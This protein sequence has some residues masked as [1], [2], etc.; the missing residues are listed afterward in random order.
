MK[1]SDII[2]KFEEMKEQRGDLTVRFTVEDDYSVYGE[3]MTPAWRADDRFW[4]GCFT[5]GSKK[6]PGVVSI[7]FHLDDKID[8]ST[9]I[10]K[11][12]KI[13]FRKG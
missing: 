13:T 6:D 10:R 8:P 9:G 3:E 11:H 5:T 1:L 4:E 12:P 7:R 2:R